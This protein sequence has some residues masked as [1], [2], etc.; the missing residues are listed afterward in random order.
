MGRINK[1]FV[2][3]VSQGGYRVDEMSD[4]PVAGAQCRGIEKPLLPPG[5]FY[6][7]GEMSGTPPPPPPPANCSQYEKG[8][9]LGGDTEQRQVP[10]GATW[11]DADTG[12][13]RVVAKCP[14][15]NVE[16]IS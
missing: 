1:S 15:L 9:A 4:E 14:F 10:T 3:Y 13:I 5:R 8:G 11:L 6:L 16:N 2:A 12:Y 7:G